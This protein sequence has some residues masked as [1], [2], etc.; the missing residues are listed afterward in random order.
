MEVSFIV[1]VYNV[2]Q[3][4][5]QSLDSILNQTHRD[6][7]VILVD[8]G[9]T[10]RSGAICDEY[11]AKDSRVRVI[12][13]ENE[14]TG[15]ARNTGM[16]AASGEYLYFCD[17]D[18]FVSPV[19]IEDNYRI[20]KENDADMVTF[21]YKTVWRKENGVSRN[22]EEVV[23]PPVLGA[24][25]RESYW[26]RFQEFGIG[27]TVWNRM[28][29]R[30][31]IEAHHIRYTNLSN[32]QDTYF[33]YDAFS[34]PFNK[35]VFND[36]MYYTYMKRSGAS[37]TVYKPQRTENEYM[38]ACRFE[39]MVTALP[40]C[41]GL[42]GGAVKARYLWVL[43]RTLGNI[44]RAGKDLSLHEKVNILKYAADKE[45]I[46]E[47]LCTVKMSEIHAKSTRVMVMLFKLRLY[48]TVVI[49]G[50]IREWLKPE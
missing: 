28:F 33:V 18:D 42:C 34:A 40:Y 47:T 41:E 48:K 21:G 7:E 4:I 10:D 17:P 5:R 1:P 26:N 44:S 27:G 19:L 43:S 2:E 8:D 45:R 12:H 14:G 3:Y 23:I 25:N 15:Y 49:L 24:Y 11:A 39:E 30:S 16:D 9:S 6:I 32:G 20:A 35:I 38:I 46:R 29:R 37:T 13:K 50:K 22:R 36:K 31:F